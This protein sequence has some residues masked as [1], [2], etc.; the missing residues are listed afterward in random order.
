MSGKK[1]ESLSKRNQYPT[2]IFLDKLMA[3]DEILQKL[4]RYKKLM[5]YEQY[6][7]ETVQNWKKN[8]VCI[9]YKTYWINPN[10]VS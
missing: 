2:E 5:Q 8:I 6:L 7:S 1:G 9:T 3:Y 10:R 4:S